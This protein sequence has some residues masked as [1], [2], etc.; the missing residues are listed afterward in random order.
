MLHYSMLRY[1]ILALHY[2]D[3]DIAISI[4]ILYYLLLQNIL[5][6]AKLYQFFIFAYC[7]I[8]VAAF[9]CC[10]INVAVFQ[11]FT[12]LSHITQIVFVL[13]HAALFTVALFKVALFLT[14]HYVMSYFLI[15]HYLLLDYANVASFSYRTI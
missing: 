12:T 2:F 3:I 6:N 15:L 11:C 1:F 13:F 4:L 10:I 8:N 9:S 7:G 14:L 5:F